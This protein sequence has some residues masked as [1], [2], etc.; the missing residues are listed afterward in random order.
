MVSYKADIKNRKKSKATKNR[1]KELIGSKVLLL[2]L[3]R[4]EKRSD[5][6]RVE[7]D[8]MGSSV[9]INK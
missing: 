7:H 2:N 8:T 9:E 4:E 3:G 6:Y 5:Y 1:L